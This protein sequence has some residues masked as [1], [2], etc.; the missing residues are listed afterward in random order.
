M[1]GQPL[2]GIGTERRAAGTIA[3]PGIEYA[4][5]AQQVRTCIRTIDKAEVALILGIDGNY[6]CLQ[7]NLRRVT[8]MQQVDYRT[9]ID[10][11]VSAHYTIARFRTGSLGFQTGIGIAAHADVALIRRGYKELC[12]PHGIITLILIFY[13]TGQ[14][15]F[16]IDHLNP[17]T[18]QID[19]AFNDFGLS[20]IL[21]GHANNVF[22]ACAIIAP[23][24]E[25]CRSGLMCHYQKLRIGGRHLHDSC[26]IRVTDSDTGNGCRHRYI[27]GAMHSH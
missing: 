9:I 3:F 11:V 12:R 4:R 26:Y 7:L 20:F 25:R 24:K 18:W 27:L 23:D 16:A 10:D 14:E 1:V 6:L 22:I 2:P 21:G 17:D 19:S 15:D 8:H 13:R 5:C